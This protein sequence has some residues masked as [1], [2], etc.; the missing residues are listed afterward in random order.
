MAVLFNAAPVYAQEENEEAVDALEK[1]EAKKFRGLE[2]EVPELKAELKSMCDQYLAYLQKDESA[3]ASRQ[4]VVLMD[5]IMKKPFRQRVDGLVSVGHYFVQNRSEKAAVLCKDKIV[6]M[7]KAPTMRHTILF[8][9]EVAELTEDYGSAMQYYDDL[10]YLDEN[11]ELV[12]NR[13]AYVGKFRN[14]DNAVADYKKLLTLNPD[15]YKAYKHLGDIYFNKAGHQTYGPWKDSLRAVAIENYRLYLEA[16]PKTADAIEFRA[17]QR[18]VST[19]YERQSEERHKDN[20]SLRTY[21]R[22]E[23]RR[24]AQLALDMKVA[25][26]PKYERIMHYYVFR[27][28]LDNKDYDL[29]KQSRSY[30]TNKLYPDS[31]YTAFDYL[32]AAELETQQEHFLE[33]I[34]YYDI[35]I[36]RYPK[37]IFACSNVVKIYKGLKRPL[38]AV[39]YQEK[40]M[41]S[42]GPNRLPEHDKIYAELFKEA[43]KLTKDS[44]VIDSL[45]KRMADAYNASID[46]YTQRLTIDSVKNDTSLSLE[47]YE[48]L[49]TLYEGAGRAE[50][51]LPIYAK[52]F[53][54]KG[55]DVNSQDIINLAR[56]YARVIKADTLK[57]EEFLPKADS[58]FAKAAVLYEK[59][60][61]TGRRDATQLCV[62]WF[63]RAGLWAPTY[64]SNLDLL[65]QTAA[66]YYMKACDLIDLNACYSD[67]DLM[68]YKISSARYPAIHHLMLVLNKESETLDEEDVKN[69]NL[70]QKYVEIILE[71]DFNDSNALTLLDVIDQQRKLKKKAK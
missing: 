56:L 23:A 32:C 13:K 28:D 49:K 21:L 11:D 62:P 65:N 45:K 37:Y 8:C 31:L 16:A 39:P 35:V 40:L 3:H 20:D 55:E 4:L 33:A 25:P 7:D 34:P 58:L 59:D 70:S 69:L 43:L 1:A 68:S 24:V 64:V 44:V 50:E 51:A 30:V 26:S 66:D 46:F 48:G 38:D 22:N 54:L 41:A 61:E 63:E 10:L 17:C 71:L 67:K 52:Y 19:M 6:Q 47:Y 2:Y 53:D 36:E 18:Y 42:F 57:R 60:V 27:C 5:T 29:A 15:E 12:F 14:E 9:A